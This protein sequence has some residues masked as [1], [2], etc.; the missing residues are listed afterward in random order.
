MPTWSA[1]FSQQ[2]P[3]CV[4][5]KATVVGMKNNERTTNPEKEE[6]AALLAWADSGTSCPLR[7]DVGCEDPPVPRPDKARTGKAGPHR[8]AS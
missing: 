8:A 6:E 4:A 5:A 2:A 3:A 1:D 7:K